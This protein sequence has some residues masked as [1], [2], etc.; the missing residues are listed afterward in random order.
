MNKEQKIKNLED[1]VCGLLD[2][3]VSISDNYN[4]DIH[5]GDSNYNY[6]LNEFEKI[7]K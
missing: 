2:E 5:N 3:I 7:T 4:I 1:L 6:Y